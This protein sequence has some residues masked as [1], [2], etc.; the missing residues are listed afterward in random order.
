MID[1]D[2][3]YNWSVW[4]YGKWVTGALILTGIIL[5]IFL[6]CIK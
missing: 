2:E 6:S 1:W 3:V 5:G 4:Q